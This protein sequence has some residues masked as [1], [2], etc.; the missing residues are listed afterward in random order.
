P[1]CGAAT[2]AGRTCQDLLHDLLGRKYAA[3]TAEYGLAIACYTL[4]HPAQQ[5]DEALEWAH[6][7]VVEAAEHDSPL[8]E[9]RMVARAQFDHL[10]Q[11]RSR[12][13]PESLRA[14]IDGLEWRRNIG[15]LTAAGFDTASIRLWARAIIADL[16]GGRC[17]GLQ[18]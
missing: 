5:T 9:I 10:D 6:F 1:E 14:T 2:I 3:E 12:A 13:P 16:N 17:P 15:D 18:R 8:D 7:Q 4:Q 11:R